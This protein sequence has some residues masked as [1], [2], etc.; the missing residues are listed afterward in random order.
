MTGEVE[1]KADLLIIGGGINGTGIARDAAGRG[2]SVVLCEKGDLG[3]ATSSASTKLVHG[4]LRY[5]EHY[6]FRLVREALAER[7]VLL[8]AAPHIIHPLRFILPQS[9]GLRPAWLIRLGLF[10]YDHLE[11]RRRLPGSGALALA[12]TPFG[13]PLLPELTNAVHYADCSVNDSRLVVLNAMDADER[14]A[15]I[16]PR[17]RFVGA[18]PLG[19]DE[20]WRVTLS[21]ASLG[22]GG[23]ETI[24]HARAIVNASGP[25][26]ERCLHDA[27]G[28]LDSPVMRLVRGSHIVVPKLFDHDNAYI[29]QNIDRRIVFA[30]PFE[31]DFTLIGTTDV[32]FHGDLDAVSPSDAEVDYLCAAINRFFINKTSPDDVVWSFSGVRPLLGSDGGRAEEVTRDYR[33]DLQR[34]KEGV[35]ALSVLGG[36]ITTY[37]KLAERALEKLATVMDIPAQPW[38]ASVPLPGG[39]ITDA[40][41]AAFSM[42]AQKNYPWLPGDLLA[43]YINTYGTRISKLLGEATGIKD[44]GQD[45]GGGLYERE[46]RY[47]VNCEWANSVEDILWRRTKLGLRADHNTETALGEWLRANIGKGTEDNSAVEEVA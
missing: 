8:A 30:I 22:E 23:A 24:I 25:W 41:M 14:G 7:E 6:E 5:L 1:H 12:G 32:D 44:M 42:S 39:D 13:A 45:F 4:G 16:L 37:R 20:G 36:K 29:F 11:K 38:T 27:I 34:T 26:A 21:S 40:D 3:S 47:L 10:I 18:D 46:A 31:R 35:A 33:L 15:T 43:R 2:L 17:T 9:P 19:N 28:G